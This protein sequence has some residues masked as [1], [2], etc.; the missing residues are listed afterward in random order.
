M[1]ENILCGV[2]ERGRLVLKH[3][4]HRAT[5]LGSEIILPHVEYMECDHCEER[6]FVDRQSE[7]CDR[8]LDRAYRRIHRL[9]TPEEI[10][11]L[12]GK[13]GLTQHELAEIIGC[14]KASLSR[15]ESGR[16]VQSRLVDNMLKILHQFPQ[17][18]D[19]LQQ[20]QRA[21]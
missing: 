17:T 15:W 13:L 9:L 18:L 7:I 11:Q 10:R 2:C 19:F 3:G 4:E 21:S 14:G 6:W 12:R 16:S 5:Y 8:E 1:G 20:R